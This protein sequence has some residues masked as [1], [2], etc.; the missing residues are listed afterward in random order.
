MISLLATTTGEVLRVTHVA[1]GLDSE[2]VLLL[3]IVINGFVPPSLSSSHVSLQVGSLPS[4]RAHVWYHKI[5]G[6]P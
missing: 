4:L 1:R 5:N 6:A 2:G 3:D